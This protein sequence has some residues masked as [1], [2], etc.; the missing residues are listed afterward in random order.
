MVLVVDEDT[1]RQQDTIKIHTLVSARPTDLIEDENDWRTTA[2][3]A[4]SFSNILHAIPKAKRFK[5]RPMIYQNFSPDERKSRDQMEIDRI[6]NYD[7]IRM[8]VEVALRLHF[9]DVQ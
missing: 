4:V 6:M 9:Q 3:N 8:T 2:H 5:H 7:A 1:A